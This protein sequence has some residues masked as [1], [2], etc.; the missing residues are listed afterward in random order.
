[1]SRREDDFETAVS[2]FNEAITLDPNNLGAVTIWPTRFFMARH[3]Q[4]LSRHL[5]QRFI[6]I[7]RPE[8]SA[9]ERLFAARSFRTSGK[10]AKEFIP[11]DR[12]N[13]AP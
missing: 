3:L 12:L 4:P 11:G 7:P 9:N 10:N 8:R 5:I 2:E 6:P 13:L 1:M